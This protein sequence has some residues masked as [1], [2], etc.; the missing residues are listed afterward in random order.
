MSRDDIKEIYFKW[1]Y[2]IV[3]ASKYVDGISYTKL[4]RQLHD[5]EFTYLI[6]RDEDRAENGINLRYRF[7]ISEGYGDI[8]AQVLHDLDNPCSVLEMMVALALSCEEE[9]MD[10]ASYGNRT[11]QWFWSMIVS[12]GLGPF[13]DSRYDRRFVDTAL[14]R[15]LNREYEPNGKGGLFTIRGC[16]ADLRHEEIWVQMCWYLDSIM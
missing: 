3:C 2:D 16:K 5:T 14:S 4:L 8:L 15:F 13:I 10:D 1:L 11:G 12:L 6:R 9:I 7:A